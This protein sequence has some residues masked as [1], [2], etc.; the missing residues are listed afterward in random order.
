MNLDVGVWMERDL[1][2]FLR[3]HFLNYV[4]VRRVPRF[5]LLWFVILVDI[6]VELRNLWWVKMNG[7]RWKKL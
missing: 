4:N 1:E 7:C 6:N 5:G 2:L 3:L